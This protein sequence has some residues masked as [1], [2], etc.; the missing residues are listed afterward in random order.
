M[1]RPS[2][3]TKKLAVKFC[4]I[5]STSSLGIKRICESHK[6]MPTEKTIHNWLN[7][8]KEFLQLYTRAKEFQADFMIDETID[9]AD[10][11]TNDT[12][13]IQMPSGAE[14][15]VENKEWTNRSKLRIETRKWIASK[16]KPKKYGDKLDVTSDG[17]KIVTPPVLN[18]QIDGEKIKLE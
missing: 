10:D 13:I 8:N 1:A 9:I 7:N 17:E 15:E 12:I 16:L 3:Y 2:K 5:I 14:R 4:Y 18:I 11:G 6:D